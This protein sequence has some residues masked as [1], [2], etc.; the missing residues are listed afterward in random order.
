MFKSKLLQ[1][2]F[3]FISLYTDIACVYLIAISNFVAQVE[4]NNESFR[5]LVFDRESIFYRCSVFFP[6]AHIKIEIDIKVY[7]YVK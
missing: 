3:K 2:I 7:V 5:T 6:S 4:Y 1:Q